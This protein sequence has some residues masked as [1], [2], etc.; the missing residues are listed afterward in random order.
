[1][2]LFALTL[3]SSLLTVGQLT[4]TLYVVFSFIV[5]TRYTARK[6]AAGRLVDGRAAPMSLSIPPS[7]NWLFVFNVV[8]MMFV[9]SAIYRAVALAAIIVFLAADKMFAKDDHGLARAGAWLFIAN[10][11]ALLVTMS[12]LY[13][14]LIV[15]GQ[16]VLL[17]ENRRIAL[18]QF[19]LERLSSAQ[20][21]QWSVVISGAVVVVAAP[22]MQLFELLL[23]MLHL[24]HPEQ[25]SVEVFRQVTRASQIIDFLI[26][27]VFLAPMI[28]ELFFRG[29]LLTYLKNY[30]ST[31]GALALSAAVFAIAHQNLDSVLPLW[32]LGIVLG[33]AYEHTGCI[34]LP[35]G[36]HACFNLTTG[37]TLLAQKVSP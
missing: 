20:L 28:E 30:M 18:K 19:G 5:I 17:L 27:A 9:N 36:I 14:L 33:V 1:M 31:W 8:T 10:V 2:T 3:P 6:V 29:F 13:M 12:P 11:L 21:I 34:L 23:D 7:G 26:Q 25:Q 15:I 32:V 35:M 22:V 4:F 24:S 16:A 37:L